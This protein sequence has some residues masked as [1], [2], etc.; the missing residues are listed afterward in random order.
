MNKA[1]IAALVVLLFTL[2][3]SLDAGVVYVMNALERNYP[4]AV[5]TNIEQANSNMRETLRL[6]QGME[7]DLDKL[8]DRFSKIN[9]G[10]ADIA[11]RTCNLYKGLVSRGKMQAG[12]PLFA[13]CK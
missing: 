1:T 3:A 11:R 4:D 2:T 9:E 5:T 12:D 7:S 13:D 8:D 10:A 6:D